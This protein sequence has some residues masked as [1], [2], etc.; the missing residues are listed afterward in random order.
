MKFVPAGTSGVLFSIWDTRV[1]D[2][3]A[4][5][6]AT[7]YNATGGMYTLGSNGW[8]QEGHSWDSPGFNQTPD[9][10]VCGVSWNDANAFC[11]WLTTMEQQSG[12]ISS[13]QVY[14]LPTDAEWSAAAGN[15]T[16]PWG[17]DWPPA[18]NEANLYRSGDGY[19]DANAVPGAD[20]YQCTSPVGT[21]LPNAYGLYDMGGNLYQFCQDFYH[22][23]MNSSDLL[24]AFPTLS[25]DGGGFTS[26]VMRG[27]SWDQLGQLSPRLAYR[28]S[29]TPDER[30]SDTGFRCV[31]T[32]PGWAWTTIL[33]IGLGLIVVVVAGYF[34]MGTKS[35]KPAS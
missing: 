20:G 1:A 30:D 5:V 11:Q 23:E 32:T 22:K 7:G 2:F 6:N 28:T 18:N 8:K 25:N 17:N 4:F 3:Q 19:T 24:Q 29:L 21:Y 34:F 33:E 35:A 16:Y 14:R 31:L 27:S 9:S 26:H 10:P 15:S 12:K 13:K